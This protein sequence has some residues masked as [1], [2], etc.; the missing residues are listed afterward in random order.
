MRNNII[1]Q[2]YDIN[3]KDWRDDFIYN[4]EENNSLA[5]YLI[6]NDYNI[7]DD[8]VLEWAYNMN[9][10]YLDDERINLNID[11]KMPIIAIAN[12]GR[13]N[14]RVSAYKVIESGNIA[15][16]LYSECDYCQWYCDDKD[17]L[18][19]GDH[20]DGTNYYLYRAISEENL[21][22]LE[23]GEIELNTEEEIEKYT[24]SLRPYIA[25][26]YWG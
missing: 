10:M 5:E 16:C 4:L 11:V 15:D 14:G 18:F 12:I 1:W 19:K 8:D 22:L 25:N 6:E 17:F 3:A 23:Y 26:V 2:N 9:S 7:D 21:E 24:T 13:W 20:H